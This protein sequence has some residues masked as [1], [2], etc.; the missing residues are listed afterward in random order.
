MKIKV[1]DKSKF[2]APEYAH[3]TDSGMDIRANIEEPITLGPL[4][5]FLVPTGKFLELPPNYEVQ[6]RPRSG[7]AAKHGV[8]VLNTPGTIT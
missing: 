8:S 2:Q 7:L 6:V 5:R 3:P 4:Q 1:V